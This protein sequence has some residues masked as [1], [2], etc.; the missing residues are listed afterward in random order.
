MEKTITNTC[1]LC[2]NTTFRHD[3]YTPQCENCLSK[4][5]HRCVK[6]VFDQYPAEFWRG[7]RLLQLSH[8]PYFAGIR[9]LFESVEISIFQDDP[10]PIDL[11][12]ICRAEHSF[13]A[14][15]CN[16]ILEHIRLDTQAIQEMYRVLAPGGILF[17]TVPNPLVFVST[18]DWGFPDPENHDHYRMYGRDFYAKLVHTLP[19][20]RVNTHKLCDP[21]GFHTQDIVF[22]II[23]Q[24]NLN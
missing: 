3:T 19:D 13:D 12:A 23:K 18:Q 9:D 11:E 6:S 22:E 4:T 24:Q 1:N 17:I 10:N 14:I 7:K 5:R 16:H 21:A 8:E 2:G 20:G 15:M